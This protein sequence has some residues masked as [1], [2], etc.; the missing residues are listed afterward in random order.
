LFVSEKSH[1]DDLH[2]NN[3]KWK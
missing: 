2:I 1:E 3:C